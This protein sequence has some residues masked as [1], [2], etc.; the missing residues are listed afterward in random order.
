MG[1]KVYVVQNQHR[2]DRDSGNLVPKYDLASAKKFGE[3]VY[4]LSPTANPFRSEGIVNE[5]RRKLFDFDDRSF[6][7]LI[8]N[9][10][11]IGIATT[12]AAESNGGKVTVLQWSGK[13]QDY[14]PIQLDL[15]RAY[16]E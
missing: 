6:L 15:G 11:L 16:R 10:V 8:G 12:L 2:L 14:R 7:L 9:P 13:D 3:L 5:M 4:L 1:K